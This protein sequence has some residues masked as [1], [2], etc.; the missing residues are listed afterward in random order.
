MLEASGL[1][2]LYLKHLLFYG[3]KFGNRLAID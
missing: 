1:G 3:P 2:P